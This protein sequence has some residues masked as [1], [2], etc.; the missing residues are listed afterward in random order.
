MTG[1]APKLVLW[2]GPTHTR[3]TTLAKSLVEA[4]RSEG[5]MVAGLLAPSIHKKNGQLAGFDAVDITTGT[6]HPL[7][8]RS[9]GGATDVGQYS[10][11]SGGE[12]FAAKA[13][14]V[15]I[16][17]DAD[18]VIVDEFG[19]LELE[20]KGWRSQVDAI[21]RPVSGLIV[22]VVRERIVDKV[23]DLYKNVNPIVVDVLQDDPVEAVIALLKQHER[24]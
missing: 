3:K 6:R 17:R 22:L 5:F 7:M 8:R 12:S 18:M 16:A 4:A 11:V 21:L 23:L 20:G 10:F 2:T 9:P 15:E 1:S 24:G 13:L 14:H 19:P